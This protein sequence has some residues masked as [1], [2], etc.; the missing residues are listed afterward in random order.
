MSGKIPKPAG[1]GARG[2]IPKPT[3]PPPQR[4]SVSFQHL[5]QDGEFS[6]ENASAN[7]HDAFF[8]RL[9]AICHFT[10]M[11]LMTNRSSA[12]R[13]HPIEFTNTSRKDGFSHLNEQLRDV[14]AYQFSVS[15][16]KHGRVDGFF[17][18]NVFHLVWLDPK[19][20]L[21]RSKG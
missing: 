3:P 17:I 6:L 21:Y 20:C 15:S 11:D 9:K 19:H 10:K 7:Y 1:G 18:D 2:S 5:T 16:N 13:F 12:L 4:V 14:P 8:E